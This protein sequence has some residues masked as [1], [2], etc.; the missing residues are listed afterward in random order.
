M[1]ILLRI[2]GSNLK[3]ELYKK[4]SNLQ[5]EIL[6][7]LFGK[8]AK[9]GKQLCY[10]NPKYPTLRMKRRFSIEHFGKQGPKIKEQ[11]LFSKTYK[12]NLRS[13]EIKMHN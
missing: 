4:R 7:Y 8:S 3:R 5:K 9:P 11:K 13:K 10:N 6:K 1:L 2:L 12:P